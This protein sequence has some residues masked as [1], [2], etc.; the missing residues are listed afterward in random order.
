MRSQLSSCL[1]SEVVAENGEVLV[2]GPDGT[3]ITMT[4]DAAEETARRLIE[5]ATEARTRAQSAHPPLTN[6][7]P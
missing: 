1:P 5:A 4:P 6:P 7:A 2:D 3:A